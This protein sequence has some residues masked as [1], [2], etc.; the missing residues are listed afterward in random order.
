MSDWARMAE[1][2]TENISDTS[3][4]HL[5]DKWGV[6]CASLQALGVGFDGADATYTFPVRDEQGNY[7]GVIEVSQEISELQNIRG[8]KRLLDWK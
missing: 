6:S 7:K 2:F 5:T 1:A 4:A 3:R 8:E